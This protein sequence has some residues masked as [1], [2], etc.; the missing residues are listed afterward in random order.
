M[1]NYKFIMLYKLSISKLFLEDKINDSI[2]RKQYIANVTIK[3]SEYF[4][5]IQKL[6]FHGKNFLGF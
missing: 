3:M 6:G 5:P 4:R 2:L 1:L